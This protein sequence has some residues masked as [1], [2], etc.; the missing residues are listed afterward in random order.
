M[1]RRTVAESNAIKLHAGGKELRRGR[2]I[3]SFFYFS[4]LVRGKRT[5][6]E[7]QRQSSKRRAIVVI[8]IKKNGGSSNLSSIESRLL[9]L[10]ETRSKVTI[11]KCAH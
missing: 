8:T 7:V 2:V 4:P 3:G 5:E 6:P 10:I 1:Q 11:V 9:R